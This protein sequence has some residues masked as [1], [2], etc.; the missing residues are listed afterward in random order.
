MTKPLQYDIAD[1]SALHAFAAQLAKIIGKRALIFLEGTL[2]AGKTSF[3]RG[4]IQALGYK[5][6]V[7]SPTYTL[8]EPYQV[9]QQQIYHFD[10]YRLADANELF[11]LGI[12][13]YLAADAIC[14]IEWPSKGEGVLPAA[15][16][17]VEIDVLPQG[18]Q[19]RLTAA[20]PHGEKILERLA[21]C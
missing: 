20:T 1:E 13:D 4:F 10:L 18:R 6:R 3:A 12:E 5:D 11:F 19:L 2:G 14:L 9:H 15:D 17:S 8:V 7:K 21:S 16:L